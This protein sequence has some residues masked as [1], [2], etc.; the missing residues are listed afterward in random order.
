MPSD[1]QPI[2]IPLSFQ[3]LDI[4]DKLLLEEVQ[5]IAD[6]PPQFFGKG[7]KLLARFLREKE[8]IGHISVYPAKELRQAVIFSVPTARRGAIDRG[9]VCR[10]C[11]QLTVLES[12]RLKRL[13]NHD[14]GWEAMLR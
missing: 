9:R 13:A 8:L 5:A 14:C 6:V 11:G 1:A 12:V 4:S 10:A 7:S 3:L 2:V